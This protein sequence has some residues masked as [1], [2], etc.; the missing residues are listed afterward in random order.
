M[1]LTKKIQIAVRTIVGAH[2]QDLADDLDGQAFSPDSIG[3]R[4]STVGTLL[5]FADPP[6]HH[7]QL[8][9]GCAPP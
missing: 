9:P 7:R 8:P 1:P 5:I 4:T 2:I 3:L 6:E